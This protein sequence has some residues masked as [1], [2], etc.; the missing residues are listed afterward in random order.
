MTSATTRLLPAFAAVLLL[1]AGAAQARTETCQPTDEKKIAGLF[2]RWN[3][4]LKT[5]D[6]AK[7]TANYAPDAVLLPT[8]ANQPHATPAEIN[9]YFV[10]F[11]KDQPQGAI[12]K[13]FIKIGCNLAQ[14]VGTYTFSFKDGNKVS[15]RYTFV[16]EF[17]GG[18][19]LIVNHHSSA[20]PVKE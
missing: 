12:D 10:K 9:G 3:D 20:M 5:L 4:S 6:P 16:Y 17:T 11:L 1:A 14:D 8:V 13:R 7:V 19:W 2:D 18:K 15:A